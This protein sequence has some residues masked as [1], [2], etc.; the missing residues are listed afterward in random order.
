[1]SQAF[2]QLTIGNVITDPARLVTFANICKAISVLGSMIV[3][4][5]TTARGL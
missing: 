1:V 3:V 4:T 5:F 2:L